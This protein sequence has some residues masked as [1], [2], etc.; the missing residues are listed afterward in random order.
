MRYHKPCFSLEKPS[1]PVRGFRLLS[2]QKALFSYTTKPV[3]FALKQ[4]KIP[5]RGYL[6]EALNLRSNTEL[7]LPQAE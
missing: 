2:Y 1:F 3:I 5:K 4:P 7:S 6:E